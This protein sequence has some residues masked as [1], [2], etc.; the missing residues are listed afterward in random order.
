MRVSAAGKKLQMGCFVADI[1]NATSFPRN[2]LLAFLLCTPARGLACGLWLVGGASQGHSGDY[3]G[4]GTKTKAHVNTITKSV[5]VWIFLLPLNFGQASKWA[6]VP[7]ASTRLFPKLSCS[8]LMSEFS[9]AF[10]SCGVGP[11]TLGGCPHS[12]SGNFQGSSNGWWLR[13]DV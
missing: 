10:M 1:A 6:A 5:L 2:L 8:V 4:E 12:W 11:R 13:F 9:E 3:D 7:R